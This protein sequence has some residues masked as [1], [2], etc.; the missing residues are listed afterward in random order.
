MP[1]VF[2]L[3]LYLTYTHI[4]YIY[5]Y[6]SSREEKKNNRS[7]LLILIR[8]SDLLWMGP[9]LLFSFSIFFIL[10]FLLLTYLFTYYFIYFS[11]LVVVE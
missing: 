1:R 10:L 5:R 11:L 4:L 6:I 3:S 9:P 8:V 7:L 2:P